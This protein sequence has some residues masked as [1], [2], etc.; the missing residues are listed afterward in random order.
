[1]LPKAKTWEIVIDRLQN[2]YNAAMENIPDY[3]KFAESKREAKTGKY[4]R[5]KATL[6]I[7]KIDSVLKNI[8]TD[9]EKLT[10]ERLAIL[11]PNQ[12]SSVQ[13][14][15]DNG[16]TQETNALLFLSSSQSSSSIVE[17][18]A[19]AL[20]LN[21]NDFASTIIDK[22]LMQLPKTPDEEA[23]LKKNPDKYYLVKETKALF[24]AFAEK[25]GLSKI[26]TEIREFNKLLKKANRFR[27][28]IEGG[29]RFIFFP[30]DYSK[31]NKE[32]KIKVD[33]ILPILPLQDSVRLTNMLR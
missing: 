21:K 4:V 3:S 23:K 25:T 20:D 14:L 22:I 2:E 29:E 10:K 17:K 7:D 27:G 13:H 26:E 24:D 28:L 33:K 5:D 12:S 31:M 8:L 30:E 16:L 18:I 1:M 9:K 15:K 6:S 19:N 32:E 11:Y